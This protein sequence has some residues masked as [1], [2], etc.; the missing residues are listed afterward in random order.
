MFNRCRFFALSPAEG[1]TIP[2]ER[3]RVFDTGALQDFYTA[4]T[5]S[6]LHHIDQRHEGAY[7]AVHAR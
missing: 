4:D 1:V 2:F 5:V 7:S 6:P 3:R